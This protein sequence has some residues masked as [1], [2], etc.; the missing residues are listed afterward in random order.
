MNKSLSIQSHPDKTLAQKLHTAQPKLYPDP[1]HKPE[2]ALA[3]N[4]FEALCSFCSTEEIQSALDQVPELTTCIGP[5]A[6]SSIRG[7]SSSQEGEEG[8]RQALKSA[9]TMLM[10]CEASIVQGAVAALTSRLTDRQAQGGQLNE[11]EA[12]ALR[13]DKQVT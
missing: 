1:N 5:E 10:T 9:F 6:C 8:A 12:L 4:S 3:L 13:L 7:I 2:M 11:K